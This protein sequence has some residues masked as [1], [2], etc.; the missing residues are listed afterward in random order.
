MK[1]ILRRLVTALGLLLVILGGGLS[2][3]VAT[4]AG[5]RLLFSLG[6]RFSD[7]LFTS[8]G[9][10]GALTRGIRV[11]TFSVNTDAVAVEGAG[12]TLTIAAGA[13]RKPV[14][15]VRKL[16]LEELQVST[17]PGPQPAP[18]AAAPSAPLTKLPVPVRL[19]EVR[20]NRLVIDGTELSVEVSG[21]AEETLQLVTRIDAMDQTLTAELGGTLMEPRLEGALTGYADVAL[22]ARV[23]LAREEV[24]L[25][26]G[27][28]S[29]LAPV[30]ERALT[31]SE[32]Q[33]ACDGP[34]L[35][36][37]CEL[38]GTVDDET[39]GPLRADVTTQ[40]ADTGAELH[41]VILS[42]TDATLPVTASVNWAPELTYQA[43]LGGENA[44]LTLAGRNFNLTGTVAVT[45]EADNWRADVP[46]LRLVQ[47]EGA[48]LSIT[49]WGEAAAGELTVVADRFDLA[50]LALDLAGLVSGTASVR[51]PW[52]EPDVTAALTVNGF[53]GFDASVT[54]IELNAA[55]ERLAGQ[56]AVEAEGVVLDGSPLG[57]GVFEVDGAPDEGRLSARW[58]QAET[59]SM[60][61]A[62][63]YRLDGSAAS[64]T[65]ES[66]Q[67]TDALAGTWRT[68]ADTAWHVDWPV[69]AL[70][71]LCLRNET[72]G[73]LCAAGKQDPQGR[74]AGNFR[75][76]QLTLPAALAG[77]L[78]A[79]VTLVVNGTGTA[80]FGEQPL[81]AE[82]ELQVTDLSVGMETETV[83]LADTRLTVAVNDNAVNAAITPT[84]D[85]ANQ[86]SGRLQTTGLGDDAAVTG[87]WN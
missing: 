80:Q 58:R 69:F 32:L 5:T 74:G 51:G 28:R 36:L 37:G 86:L 23:H 8:R 22:T 77:E 83:V 85:A 46:A 7:G 11:A 68:E 16:V 47:G 35:A 56:A 40:L 3:L 66:L 50:P 27:L 41:G 43:H 53:N 10:E 24:T 12:L 55:L 39:L 18:V 2:W 4:E 49:G 29:P 75:I 57:A 72:A 9:V 45:G 42:G 63:A 25:K 38:T 82:A 79:P 54:R 20:V 64:G 84:T 19:D 33:L 70:A 59:R 17:K 60:R 76:D 1:R 21:R 44:G 15:H 61:L 14:A 73:R 48:N 26:A 67:L 81:I 78:P 31:V 13:L 6:E 30:P 71:D 34:F 87:G 65:L 62:T 52:Q